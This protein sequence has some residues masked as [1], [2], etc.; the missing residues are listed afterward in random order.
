[1]KKIL[2]SLFISTLCFSL[3]KT[4]GQTIR[5]LKKTIELQM[6]GED[7]AN[8]GSVAWHTVQKKYYAAMAGNTSYPLAVF[9][10]SGKKLSPD[11]LITFID[12]RGLWYNPETKKICGNGFNDKGWFSYQLNEK[13]IPE[14]ITIILEGKNQPG[15]QS[16]GTYNTKNKLLYFIS[17]K[18]VLAY[19]MEGKPIEDS[20]IQLSIIKIPDF[21]GDEE[22][23]IE[24][25]FNTTTVVYSGI[26]KNEYGLL[27][28]NIP[29][30]E[31]YNK[32]TGAISQILKLPEG[33]LAY[34][35]FNF[36][37]ANGIYWLFDKDN[38]KWIGYK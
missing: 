13:G 25:N 27:N 22:E 21:N 33:T 38:R 16:V 29:Q 14:D 10:A 20:S 12:V 26:L 36:S 9:D 7:G 35:W 1:M 2:L 19:D 6:P 11:E 4:Y 18:S 15:E 5:V 28:Y 31:L 3:L 8:G 32:N 34:N 37:F 24:D 17:G 30:I 23:Y